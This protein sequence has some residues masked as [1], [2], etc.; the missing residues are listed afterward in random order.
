M[1]SFLKL[2]LSSA[3]VIGIVLVAFV[4][5]SLAADSSNQAN[6]AVY[7]IGS[8]SEY[9]DEVLRPI[10]VSNRR[11]YRYHSRPYR[12]RYYRSP[13][14]SYGYRHKHPYY[15]GKRYYGHG[16]RYRHPFGHRL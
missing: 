4:H 5:A 7:E 15:Y 1:N 11:Y 8:S 2:K 12:Y 9:M 6:S 16:Y 10:K 13:Y 14:R 3:A